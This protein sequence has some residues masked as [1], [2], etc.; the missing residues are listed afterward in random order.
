MASR[1]RGVSG[2]RNGGVGGGIRT[3]RKL[4]AHG[5]PYLAPSTLPP[6]YLIWRLADGRR[7]RARRRDGGFGV[8]WRAK[9]KTNG[10]SPG[11]RAAR[12]SSL[13]RRQQHFAALSRHAIK[14]SVASFGINN[15]S[16]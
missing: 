8:A 7:A 14:H 6:S 1:E 4:S 16:A 10:S 12:A 11:K 15:I 2:M 13:Q 9:R 3:W 5:I